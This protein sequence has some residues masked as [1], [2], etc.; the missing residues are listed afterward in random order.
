[1]FSNFADELR[2]RRLDARLS[3]E[4]L[5]EAARVSASAI[6]AY[7]RGTRKTPH[8]ETVVMLADALRLKGKDRAEFEAAARSTH[9]L[10]SKSSKDC[11]TLPD[12]PGTFFGD[13]STLRQIA[14]SLQ[15]HRLVTLVG[16]GGVGK[17]RSAMRVAKT[18]FQ[19]PD[20]VRLV[21][22]SLLQHGSQVEA[23]LAQ[24]HLRDTLLIVDNCE[25]LVS[26]VGEAVAVV[27]RNRPTI[28]V[29][30]TSRERLRIA[31][32]AVYVVPPLRYPEVTPS[33]S[34]SALSYPSVA[35][36][37]ERA[38]LS[39][40]ALR[41]DRDREAVAE[42]CRFLA[43]VPLAIELAA[44]QVRALGVHLLRDQLRMKLSVLSSGNR[45]LPVR[46]QTL[47][48]TLSWSYDLL[49]PL[50]RLLFRRL[51]TFPESF[52]AQQVFGACTGPD[53]SETQALNALASL[54]E[55]SMVW[56]DDTTGESLYRLFAVERLFALEKA[57]ENGEVTSNVQSVMTWA[58]GAGAS[59]LL[60]ASTV[61][62]L[63][64]TWVEGCENLRL[65]DSL[66]SALANLDVDEIPKDD[67]AACWMLLGDGLD[68]AGEHLRA[69]A[70][71]K[72]AGAL[73]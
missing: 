21:D 62:H 3:Q 73:A 19:K 64:L 71:R 47:H 53:L 8:R 43:G 26:D 30:A 40:N 22:A 24:T 23:A 52:T 1:M 31:G 13:E 66:G 14:T 2:S 59:P 51:G 20:R 32:E 29:L 34:E 44:S 70:A 27:L 36:F 60:A 54:V 38:G 49:G 72:C 7:E 50:D 56:P 46:Q 37:M 39:I 68:E 28:T 45:D 41:T 48:A 25:H 58:L 9:R 5:A 11:T 61:R 55:K 10:G 17:S 15:K 6:G 67:L 4:E 69:D 63:S 35:L 33:S 18:F 16:T 12:E 65:L 57:I 42:I